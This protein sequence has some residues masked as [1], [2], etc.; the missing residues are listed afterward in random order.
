M[1]KT[2]RKRRGRGSP[3]FIAPSV[4]E[5][6]K[7]IRAGDK[8][9]SPDEPR[10][11]PCA[12]IRSV[13]I[14]ARP[15]HLRFFVHP[16]R[17]TSPHRLPLPE[18]SP[19][20]CAS[21]ASAAPPSP[22]L[23]RRHHGTSPAHTPSDP[24]THEDRGDSATTPSGTAPAQGD[25]P[26][27]P[28]PLPAAPG[29]HPTSR[30]QRSALLRREPERLLQHSPRLSS[31]PRPRP[32]RRAARK[33]SAPPPPIGSRP[34]A[35]STRHGRPARRYAAG[36]IAPGSWLP[37]RFAFLP[38]SARRCVRQSVARRTRRR[39]R[40]RRCTHRKTRRACR[41]QPAR[42]AATPRARSRAHRRGGA[43]A[44]HAHRR[45]Q[46]HDRS[47]TPRSPAKLRT[48]PR[49]GRTRQTAAPTRPLPLPRA[50]PQH[51]P[52][53]TGGRVPGWACYI[54]QGDRADRGAGRLEELRERGRVREGVRGLCAPD[55]GKVRDAWA[56]ASRRLRRAWQH[57]R[58]SPA[59]RLHPCVSAPT[60][61][62]AH[63]RL[64]QCPGYV[65]AQM[66]TGRPRRCSTALSTPCAQWLAPTPIAATATCHLLSS[67]SARTQ[68]RFQEARMTRLWV[69]AVVSCAGGRCASSSFSSL[70]LCV[71]ARSLA[72]L[73][74]GLTGP[75]IA[76]RACALTTAKPR[77]PATPA[78][79][80]P[81]GSTRTRSCC[82]CASTQGR[83]GIRDL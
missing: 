11:P 45:R 21:T 33:F 37:A 40:R 35:I 42:S 71:S 74:G 23:A 29:A 15:R 54:R 27:A 46:W 53:A 1:G 43:L 65:R 13:H 25:R 82:T 24:P 8:P 22:A 39:R 76:R 30:Q 2:A 61:T 47:C 51:A 26:P 36:P 38:L 48:P 72:C 78:S 9:P 7:I 64:R 69:P 16:P 10:R 31:A 75:A 19:P 73:R 80:A 3:P 41:A 70:L 81:A 67:S 59:A 66:H 28:S 56:R 12:P 77:W 79:G 57:I 68:M 18:P 5:L 62:D 52:R 49:E 58:V 20:P 60:R 14:Q 44:T 55:A 17:A 34:R 6:R 4:I 83:T 63:R 32:D 50:R